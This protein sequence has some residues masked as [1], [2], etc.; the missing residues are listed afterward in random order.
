MEIRN[1]DLREPSVFTINFEVGCYFVRS[2]VFSQE[3]HEEYRCEMEIIV[4][5]EVVEVQGDETWRDG[6]RRVALYVFRSR[7]E[8]IRRR[9]T[10]IVE[11]SDSDSAE[12]VCSQAARGRW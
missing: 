3:E 11:G 5:G 4:D 9:L 6:N 2:R 10:N 1:R 12:R 8:G 7:V